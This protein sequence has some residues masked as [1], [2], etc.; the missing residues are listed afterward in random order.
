MRKIFTRNL[1]FPAVL[2]LT[3]ALQQFAQPSNAA[4]PGSIFAGETLKYEGRFAKFGFSFSVAELT[5]SSAMAPNGTDLIVKA[6]AVS[7]GTLVKMFRFSFLQQY[8]STVELNG[9][10]VIKSTKHDVQKERVRDSE[11]VFDYSQRRV[12]YVETDPKDANRPPR[13]IA[14]EIGDKMNDLISGIFALRLLPLAE[15]KRFEI[16]VS[17]SGIVYKVPVVVTRREELKTAIGK[18]WC[19]RVEPEVF[20]TGR[21]IEQKGRMVIWVTDDDRRTPVRSQVT[22]SVG[23]IDIKIRSADK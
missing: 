6:E 4:R 10:R 5:I 20:G 9:F 19:F 16:P 11:A 18:V 8:E 12:T 17:D 21:L 22:A 3:A 13:R 1:I 15:G 23:K 7:K 14:S 2:I